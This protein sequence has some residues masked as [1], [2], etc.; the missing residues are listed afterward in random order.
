MD[1]RVVIPVVRSESQGAAKSSW[2]E[3]QNT[4]HLGGGPALKVASCLL[5]DVGHSFRWRVRKEMAALIKIRPFYL[6]DQ[7]ISSS[8]CSRKLPIELHTDIVSTPREIDPSERLE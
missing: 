3:S 1:T 4:G 7:S 8:R 6:Q 5:Q 2:P